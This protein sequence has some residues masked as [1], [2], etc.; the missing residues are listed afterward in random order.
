MHYSSKASFRTISN[1]A[2]SIVS[3]LHFWQFD[4]GAIINS[5]GT[6]NISECRFVRNTSQA[7]VSDALCT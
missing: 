5:G 3:L 2:V 6:M 1:T 4:G 7:Y